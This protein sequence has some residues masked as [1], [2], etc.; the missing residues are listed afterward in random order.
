MRD[1]NKRLYTAMD[2]ISYYFE[3]ISLNSKNF[4]LEMSIMLLI[5]FLCVNTTINFMAG[6]DLLTIQSW[7]LMKTDYNQEHTKEEIIAMI[8]EI[9]HKLGKGVEN[10]DSIYFLNLLQEIEYTPEI[11]MSKCNCK[12]DYFINKSMIVAIYYDIE[13][14][15]PAS[16]SLAQLMLESGCGSSSMA[17]KS[18]NFFGHKCGNHSHWIDPDDKTSAMHTHCT[19]YEDD[20]KW[21]TFLNFDKFNDSWW[22]RYRNFKTNKLRKATAKRPAVYRYAKCF[23]TRDYKHWAHELRAAGY[24]TDKLYAEKLIR[25]IENNNFQV[26]DEL[27]VK[28]EAHYNNFKTRALIKKYVEAYTFK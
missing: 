2:D 4:K 28:Y 21:N 15:I 8:N 26:L 18:H 13:Y 12:D 22:R 1:F 16:I 19:Y 20:R 14:G 10:M 23:E 24:A 11:D 7:N 3:N 17:Q 6:R 25:I 5:V 9:N 27:I